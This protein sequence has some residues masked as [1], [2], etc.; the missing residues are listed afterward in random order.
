MACL[1]AECTKAGIVRLICETKT[2]ELPP[3]PKAPAGHAPRRMPDSVRRTSTV[4]I[5]WPGGRNGVMRVTGRARDI[6]TSSGPAETRLLAEGAYEANLASDRRILSIA[7]SPKAAGVAALQG[8]R[9]GSHLRGIIAAA[10]P[11][12]ARG[13]TPLYLILDDLSG[14]S[15]IAPWA[16][17]RWDRN[18]LADIARR[19]SDPGFAAAFNRENICAGLRTG[20]SGLSFGADGVAAGSLRHPDDP[21]GWH[22][23]VSQDGAAMRRARRIDVSCDTVIRIDAH[24]QDSAT[25]PEGD[26][27]ALHEYRLRATADPDSL[28]LLSIEAEPRVLPFAECPA[29]APNVSRLIGTKLPV[30]R[31]AVLDALKGPAGCTHLNDALRAL[32]DVPVLLRHVEAKDCHVLRIQR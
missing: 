16:W 10:L 14:V 18:W 19:K 22:E 4:D 1:R 7:A 23:F 3:P 24:F 20:S 27:S 29:A 31:Q 8:E 30:L 13:G 5:D 2:D 17:S 15:L 28:A 9:A 11:G 25:T 32:A 26:R 21:E 6:L 12:E